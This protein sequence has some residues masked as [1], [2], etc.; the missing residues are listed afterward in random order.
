LAKLVGD[1]PSLI[2]KFAVFRFSHAYV[3][4]GACLKNEKVVTSARVV[5][6]RALFFRTLIYSDRVSQATMASLWATR[7]T[8]CSSQSPLSRTHEKNIHSGGPRDKKCTI[9]TS[10][11]LSVWAKNIFGSSL[12]IAHDGHTRQTAYRHVLHGSQFH[13]HTSTP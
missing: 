12:I 10:K 13:K 7:I 9:S 1:N 2:F 11:C 6:K 8:A 5:E 3:H 4:G